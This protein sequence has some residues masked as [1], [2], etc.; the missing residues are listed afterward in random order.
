MTKRHKKGESIDPSHLTDEELITAFLAGN[1]ESFGILYERYYAQVYGLLYRLL[2]DGDY[3]EDA[4][5]QTFLKA[6]E[7]LSQVREKSYFSIW[8]KRIAT[9]VALNSLRDRKT[10]TLEKSVA[11][12]ATAAE[13]SQGVNVTPRDEEMVAK[14]LFK[15]GFA[16]KTSGE[17]QSSSEPAKQSN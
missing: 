6:Y 3:V 7:N 11:S 1:E 17:E 12:P 13:I 9:N 10:K 16:D 8:L 15:L 4:A 2:R 5:Q 14:V